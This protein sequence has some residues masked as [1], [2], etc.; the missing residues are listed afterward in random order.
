MPELTGLPPVS[1]TIVDPNTLDEKLAGGNS[2]YPSPGT[3][4]LNPK[5]QLFLPRSQQVLTPVL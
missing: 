5:P 2:F 4:T 1:E 3:R